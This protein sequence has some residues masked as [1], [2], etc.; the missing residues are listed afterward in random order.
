M[1]T[2]FLGRLA[3][4]SFVAVIAATFC[5][6]L[7]AE[8]TANGYGVYEEFGAPLYAVKLDVE[9]R[10]E[11]SAVL[12]A[13]DHQKTLTL[14]VLSETV[15][16]RQ[17]CRFWTQNIAINISTTDLENLADS[18]LNVCD[19]ING[20]LALGDQIVFYRESNERTLLRVNNIDLGN[21]EGSGIFEAFLSPFIGSSPVSN[22]LKTALLSQPN[23]NSEAALAFLSSSISEERITLV[24]RWVTSP[25]SLLETLPAQEPNF[26]SEPEITASNAKNPA[27]TTALTSSVLHSL[28]NFA[29]TKKTTEVQTWSTVSAEEQST[30]YEISDSSHEPLMASAAY[31]PNTSPIFATTTSTLDQIRPKDKLTRISLLDI[32]EY[33]NQSLLRVYGFVE[34]PSLAQRRGR[35]GSLRL[36]VDIDRDGNIRQISSL[37]TTRHSELNEAAE[38]AVEQAAPFDAPPLADDEE[39]FELL[40]PIRFSLE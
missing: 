17:W 30:I 40:L 7:T 26:E 14:R 38:F 36:K 25:E 12:L 29:D 11:N 16:E 19:Q 3:R 33:Q 8:Q 37:E 24:Q 18:V 4:L 10:I 31:I 22:S 28:E 2:K 21:L 35:E 5:Q 27:G 13:D 6:N 32:Q 39:F 1:D 23:E 15:G 34:Y 9:Q 20:N